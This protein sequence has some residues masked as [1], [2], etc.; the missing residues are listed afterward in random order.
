MPEFL[1]E[2]LTPEELKGGFEPTD[3]DDETFLLESI[4]NYPGIL[5]YEIEFRDEVPIPKETPREA[6]EIKSME[7]EG[8]SF[9]ET[10][11]S[12]KAGVLG[13]DDEIK[14]YEKS[15]LVA[16]ESEQVTYEKS[17]LVAEESEQVT[18]E[19]SGLVAEEDEQVTY[20]K[21]GLVAEED[22][23]VTYEKS[24]LVAEESEQVTYEKSGSVQDETKAVG[25]SG[26][27]SVWDL[28]EDETEPAIKDKEIAE[29]RIKDE[30]SIQE[31]LEP[32][33]IATEEI[34]QEDIMESIASET[35]LK[36]IEAPQVEITIAD[37]NE[38]EF[39]RVLDED[40]RKGIEEELEQSRERRAK[41]EKEAEDIASEL[42]ATEKE[43]L[44]KDL[45]DGMERTGAADFIEIDLTEMKVR[46][47]SE[48]LAYE[49]KENVNFSDFL[50]SE[51]KMKKTKKVKKQKKAGKPKK[52]KGE[53]PI[54]MQS[55]EASA[56]PQKEESM[57][58]EESQRWIESEGSPERIPASPTE[59]SETT[60]TKK[61]KL[62]PIWVWFPAAAVILLF[63]IIGGYF[64][65]TERFLG[66]KKPEI[67]KTK[68][69][70]KQQ[71]KSVGLLKDNK[72]AEIITPPA[73]KKITTSEPKQVA[74]KSIKAESKPEQTAKPDIKKESK[75]KISLNQRVRTEPKTKSDLKPEKSPIAKMETPVE[76]PVAKIVESTPLAE[77]SIE[78]FSSSEPDEA[79][80]WKNVLNKKGIDALIKIHKVRNVNVYCVRVG[81]FKNID[82]A[83][84]YAKSQGFKN[85][86]IDRIK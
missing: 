72:S 73:E 70:K 33:P 30:Q 59:E 18:Y 74:E 52:V 37:Y 16:E 41:I 56:I 53:P 58:D 25:K 54:A 79:N 3:K 64:L 8:E 84:A 48:F 46:K 83:R 49:M 36:G 12:T 9:G 13:S 39:E 61:K 44:Q 35:S 7:E 5:P 23:Q 69:D 15:G 66:N 1:D 75:P 29:T 86:W 60:E 17:G 40:F 78:V 20:E 68:V 82:E 22:E 34:V 6:A 32:Q 85:I 28:F 42:T 67:V 4:G 80:Y 10:P 62:I 81:T 47:P 14:P 57:Q 50:K 77:Y 45:D 38:E 51:P 43:K 26:L 19:K 24:G 71:Q 31:A 2:N 11:T 21:S 55:P 27:P 76:T 63:V 65:L